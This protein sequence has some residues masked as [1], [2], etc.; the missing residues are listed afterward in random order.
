MG[1]GGGGIPGLDTV[2]D[3]LATTVGKAVAGVTVLVFFIVVIVAST[4]GG[5]GGGGAPDYWNNNPRGKM[6]A[7]NCAN[8]GDLLFGEP[9]HEY[10]GH[11]YQLVGDSGSS[12]TWMDR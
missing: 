1:G 7:A 10:D 11:Y 12:L 6:L 4:R 9:V 5:G 8:I 2:K 3:F